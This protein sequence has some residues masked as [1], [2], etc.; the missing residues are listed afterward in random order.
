MRVEPGDIVA[1]SE[2]P[3]GDPYIGVVRDTFGGV[4]VIVQFGDERAM[5]NP[6]D[7][8]VPLWAAA[9]VRALLGVRFMTSTSELQFVIAVCEHGA[10]WS[11]EEAELAR[12]L[13]GDAIAGVRRK[14]LEHRVTIRWAPDSTPIIVIARLHR[15]H[16]ATCH[17]LE[18]VWSPDTAADFLRREA[19]IPLGAEC[20]PPVAPCGGRHTG[21]RAVP[22]DQRRG[23]PKPTPQ[24]RK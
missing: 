16:E 22:R 13:I 15:G 1:V 10:T 20:T 8:L 6:E 19:R 23:R 21:T 11:E 18:I 17:A 4:N 7:R 3:E 9:D 14:F 12:R 24:R 2:M 5:L